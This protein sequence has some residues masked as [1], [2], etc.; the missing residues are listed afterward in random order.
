LVEETAPEDVG[1]GM[2]EWNQV[3][4]QVP[5]NRSEFEAMSYNYTLQFVK[6]ADTGIW[7]SSF[8]GFPF[9]LTVSTRL[10]FSYIK[11]NSPSSISIDQGWRIFKAGAAMCETG[12]TPISGTIPSITVSSPYLGEDS[13]IRRWK[14][15]IW[16]KRNRYVPYPEINVQ[17]IV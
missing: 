1:G 6:D 13:Q 11:T 15:N 9:A 5:P 7:I 8:E 2:V 14:G 17:Y 12:S 16:E 10:D 4:Y 3:Y